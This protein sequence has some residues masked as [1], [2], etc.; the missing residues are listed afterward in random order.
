MV[1]ALRNIFDMMKMIHKA[2][3]RSFL[4]TLLY[5]FWVMFVEL[6]FLTLLSRYLINAYALKTPYWQ[7]L[8]VLLVLWI[9]Q[10]GYSFFF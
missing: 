6:V 7:V 8:C 3:K 9:T 2:S 5:D 10:I 1:K 4:M